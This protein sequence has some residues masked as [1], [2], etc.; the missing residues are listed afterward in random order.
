MKK[1]FKNNRKYLRLKVLRFVP[2]ILPIEYRVSFYSFYTES[3]SWIQHSIQSISLFSQKII[4]QL[5]E[6]FFALKHF[7]DNYC[8]LLIKHLYIFKIFSQNDELIGF[9]LETKPNSNGLRLSEL[10]AEK[11]YE[12]LIHDDKWIHWVFPLNIPSA[13]DPSAPI[14]D[15]NTINILKN[16][17]FFIYKIHPLFIRAIGLYGLSLYSDNTIHRNVY[18]QNKLN[19]WFY[20]NSPHFSRIT[21][22][23]HSL[24][25]LLGPQNPYGK[26]LFTIM[27]DIYHNEGQ[28]VISHN[29]YEDWEKALRI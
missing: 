2:M 19:Q 9:Y 7:C 10:Y 20:T 13:D 23:I 15:H 11:S 27:K 28:G 3:Q 25:L 12:W 29:Y 14:L 17:K 4:E 22:I 6:L 18:F 1:N 5:G 24:A 8:P 21:R 26:A 16:N